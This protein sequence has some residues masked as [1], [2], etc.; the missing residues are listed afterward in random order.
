MLNLNSSNMTSNSVLISGKVCEKI[1][2]PG[3]SFCWTLRP[4]AKGQGHWKWCKMV[5]WMVA[6]SMVGIKELCWKVS[7]QCSAFK[8]LHSDPYAAHNNNNNTN[9]NNNNNNNERIYRPLFHVKH[10]ELCW[11]V[12]IQKCKTH[13]YKTPKTAGV[14]TIMLK[15]PTKQIKKN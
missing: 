13:T 15:H 9:N 3:F 10:A 5:R 11:Q 7:V 14:Q 6:V 12:Q 2:P 8:L 1:K 4:L